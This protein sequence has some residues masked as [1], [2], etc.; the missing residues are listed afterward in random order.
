MKKVFVTA[1]ALSVMMCMT[2]WAD[3]DVDRT[4]N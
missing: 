4:G 3:Q 2:A 1:A